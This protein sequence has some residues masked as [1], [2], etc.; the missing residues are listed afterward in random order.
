MKYLKILGLAA[1][2]AKALTALFGAGSASASGKLCNTVNCQSLLA[3]GTNITANLITPRLSSQRARKYSA[4]RLARIS[5][6]IMRL[7]G[8]AKSLPFLH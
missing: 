5:K 8:Q 2:A 4:I 1:V 3:N 6:S 7:M